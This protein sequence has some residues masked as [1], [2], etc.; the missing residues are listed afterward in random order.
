MVDIR[1]VSGLQILVEA[2]PLRD[3]LLLP[4]PEPCLLLLDLLCE[5]LPQVLLLFLKLGVVE[6]SGTGLAKLAGLHLLRAVRLVVLLL[7][8]VDQIQHVGADQDAAELLE[9]TMILVLN[10]G[11]SPRVLSA[12]HDAAVRG[13]HILLAADDGERHGG[14]QAA[15]VLG[16]G[17]IILL[18]R[19][20]VDLDALSLDN[21][22]N[23]QQSEPSQEHTDRAHSYPLLEQGQVVRRQGVRLR[24]DGD[25]VDT[26]RQ[27]LHNF[28]VERLE[29][30]TS[31]P[32]EVQ[33]GVDTEVD[34]VGTAGLLL[35]E[36]VRLVLVVN[37]LD[38][39]HP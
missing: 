11:N 39:R 38:N 10:L 6:L 22:A 4:L 16:S 14:H 24:N 35:L 27:T 9:V 29:R 15:G 1:S 19:G 28:D 30:V 13:L 34:L 36:H 26:S 2:V 12:L 20:L 33:T 25:Q 31:R 7:G 17:L 37:E 5:P 18:D 8:R 23:L 32:D 3:E 21:G